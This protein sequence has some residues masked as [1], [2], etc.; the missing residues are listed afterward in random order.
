M[1]V[2]AAIATG[3]ES[4]KIYRGRFATTAVGEKTAEETAMEQRFCL[5]FCLEVA[6]ATAKSPGYSDKIC[7]NH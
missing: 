3:S 6:A 5:D 4:V 2:D 7:C 1:V